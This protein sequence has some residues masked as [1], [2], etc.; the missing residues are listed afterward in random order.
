MGKK[1]V[2]IG[3]GVSG[4][5]A[6]IYGS[7]AGFD[8]VVLEKNST[9]G[10]SC[11]GW[12]RKGYAIDNCLHWL[13]GTKEGTEVY[14]MWT[15]L[16]VL[17]PDVKQITRDCFWSSE[18]DGVVVTLWPDAEKSRRE[19]LE[20]SPEDEMEINAFFDVVGLANDMVTV[21]PTAKELVQTAHSHQT[22]LSRKDFM[23]KAMQYLGIRN[24]DW[25]KKF[26][27]KA[28]QNLILDFCPKEYESY[29]LMLSY[30][31]YVSGNGNIID[32]GSIKMAEI[33]VKSLKEAGGTLKTGCPVK[34]VVIE[35]KTQKITEV[36]KDGFSDGISAGAAATVSKEIAL[37][38]KADL[39]ESI[40]RKAKGVL[41]ENGDFIEADYVICACDVNYTFENLINSKYAPVTLKEIYKNRLS[42]TFYSAFQVAFAVDGEFEEV[43]DSLS[44]A[45]EPIDAAYE[46]YDRIGIKNYRKYGDYIA[47]KGKTVIQVS[48]DQY[49]KDC[50]YWRRLYNKD[51]GEYT[52]A[53][54][55]IADAIMNAIVNRFPQYEGKLDV[56]DVWTPYSYQRRNNDTHGA[57][58]R[59][60]TT[61]FSLNSFLSLEIKGLD[62]VYLSGHW[63]KYPG[64]V[65][66]AAATGKDAV[67]LIIEKEKS[68]EAAKEM[69][70]KF[71][72]KVTNNPPVNAAKN[73]I[74]KVSKEEVKN[75]RRK[76]DNA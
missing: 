12:Y 18:T 73:A 62:N 70:K 16:G 36:V 31:F 58:M 37:E 71:S 29:W 20:I 33:L 19:W 46:T 35:R 28:I 51:R 39:K 25:V 50:K 3:G 6:G 66:M 55:N 60:I 11:S 26:K 24:Y 34:K 65:P 44:F 47:P 22:L 10:G 4:L 7:R 49:E 54:E 9:A 67:N 42:Y 32:G 64:G 76:R 53:K 45:C 1:L 15:E 30:S 69:I 5:S 13:T 61:A 27:S 63:M 40:V 74:K 8:T 41:L 43:P 17:G 59:F 72:E 38:L 52:R 21:N 23:K 68:R 56:L 14:D 75:N 2:I 57:F 48:L